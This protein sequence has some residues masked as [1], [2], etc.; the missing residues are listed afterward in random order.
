MNMASGV[1][2]V[3]REEQLIQEELDRERRARLDLMKSPEALI[4]E[5]LAKAR[6]AWA[7]GSCKAPDE[8]ELNRLQDSFGKCFSLPRE[9]IEGLIDKN[10]RMDMDK[11]CMEWSEGAEVVIGEYLESLSE[12]EKE[13]LHEFGAVEGVSLTAEEIQQAFKEVP[14]LREEHDGA[15]KQFYAEKCKGLCQG[16]VELETTNDALVHEVHKSWATCHVAHNHIL[17]LQGAMQQQAMEIRHL[18]G[19]L[20]RLHC[21]EHATPRVHLPG[22]SEKANKKEKELQNKVQVLVDKCVQPQLKRFKS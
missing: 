21:V 5:R 17:A 20:K 13:E 3:D 4:L 16:C 8:E 14:Q 9:Y 10:S 1:P 15:R 19:E 6:N 12:S 2:V 11:M 18:R 7:A 22:P